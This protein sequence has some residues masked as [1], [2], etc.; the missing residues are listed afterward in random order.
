MQHG[1]KM[2]IAG[3]SM[4]E[5]VKIARRLGYLDIP[6]DLI[7]DFDSAKRLSPEQIVIMAT[8]AQGEP[9]AVLG[10]IATG[11]HNQIPNDTVIMSAEPI[12]G[13]EEMVHRIIN[14][15]YQRGANVVYHAIAPVHVSGHASQDE[16][17]LL[18]N[19]VRPRYFV[20]IHGELRHLHQHARLAISLG[21]PPENVAVVENG[22]VLEFD[23]HG[24]HI[25]ERMPGG[26]V[27]VD[28]AGVGDVSPGLLRDREILAQDGMVI[29]NLVLRRD[30][31]RAL[32]EPEIVSRGFI[33]LDEASEL[34]EDVK[35][36]VLETVEG[37]KGDDG[38]ALCE[39]TEKAIGAFLYEETKRRPV[40]FALVTMV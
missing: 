4:R 27:F 5:N 18:I 19:M 11:R 21:I 39:A 24:M 23:G 36:V 14:R 38:E 34:I 16:M 25:G 13:N 15:L 2:M 1:R 37:R 22:T 30:T 8:G 32:S 6:D 3:T 9:L 31:R 17:K 40:V 33:H 35:R 20:P 12:P 7:V 26:Y 28:G 29:V 10:R